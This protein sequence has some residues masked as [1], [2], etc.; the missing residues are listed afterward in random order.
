MET[1]ARVAR[2]RR[3]AA[4]ELFRFATM[5]AISALVTLGLPIFLHEMLHIG[6]KA[7]VA[8]GQAS[9]FSINFALIRVFVFRSSGH[10]G[11]QF[12]HYA[13]SAAVF[14]GLEYVAFL[15][16]FQWAGLFYVT[17]LVITLGTSTLIKFVWYRFLF[18]GEK[19]AAV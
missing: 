16:L 4:G 11:R 12:L 1:I 13:G 10:L 19:A 17:A 6:Q 9:V 5:S 15:A 8:C 2:S 14:R 3:K 18:G 7:A